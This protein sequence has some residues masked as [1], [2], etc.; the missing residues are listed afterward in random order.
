MVQGLAHTILGTI[1]QV[2]VFCW[3]VGLFFSIVFKDHKKY[4]DWSQKN[5]LGFFKKHWRYILCI[6]I[7]YLLSFRAEIQILPY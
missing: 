6:F 4:L 1:V 3:F 7:G 5:I 2:L